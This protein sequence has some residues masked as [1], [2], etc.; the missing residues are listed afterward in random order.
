MLQCGWD[1]ETK[2]EWIGAN[3][4][5][6]GAAAN[7]IYRT[8]VPN[9][10]LQFRY[11][12][13]REEQTFISSHGQDVLSRSSFFSRKDISTLHVDDFGGDVQDVAID[14]ESNELSSIK[15]PKPT[16]VS[17]SSSIQMRIDGLLQMID[18]IND[19]NSNPTID[20]KAHTNENERESK[21]FVHSPLGD[22]YI[23]D[24]QENHLIIQ[25]E[26]MIASVAKTKCTFIQKSAENNTLLRIV[27]EN[28]LDRIY[29]LEVNGYPSDE[30]AS[31]E[32]LFYRFIF[33]KEHFMAF[34]LI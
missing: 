12:M 3:Y 10:R 31:K 7:D 4:Q 19:D 5:E 32:K 14:S 6:Q 30:A 34:S 9:S 8:N 24:E 26:N 11:L 21:R 22:G 23:L 15:I 29:N 17:V 20:D 18:S 33:A 27:S 28:D 2:Q 1:E 13:L 25:M 16:K